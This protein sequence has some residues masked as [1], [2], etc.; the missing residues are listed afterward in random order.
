VTSDKEREVLD[1]DM[2]LIQAA[3]ASDHTIVS[4][5]DAARGLFAAASQHARALQSVVWINPD[6][7]EGQPIDWLEDGAKAEPQ[8][9]LSDMPPRDSRG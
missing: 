6:S 1:K 9:M 5:D 7:S 3:M 4:C 2:L 8:R